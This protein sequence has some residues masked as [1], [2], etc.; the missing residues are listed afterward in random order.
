MYYYVMECMVVYC[1]EPR[2]IYD[3]DVCRVYCSTGGDNYDNTHTISSQSQDTQTCEDDC[4]D[5]D[6]FKKV[7]WSLLTSLQDENIHRI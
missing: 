7:I 6:A 1:T 5:F 2:T 4:Y 3:K